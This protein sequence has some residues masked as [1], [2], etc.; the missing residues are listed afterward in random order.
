[1][2]ITVAPGE[3]FVRGDFKETEVIAVIVTK[4]PLI[5]IIKVICEDVYGLIG[6][7]VGF[8]FNEDD[9]FGVGQG[10]GDV[11]V[12]VEVDELLRI[13]AGDDEDAPVEPDKPERNEVGPLRY[14]ANV[15]DFVFSPER[16]PFSSHNKHYYCAS[17]TTNRGQGAKLCSV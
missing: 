4:I 14:R 15:L 17:F 7:D 13:G 9:K 10:Q 6:S 11:L 12:V 3:N 8:T 2:I 1:V 5:F 16:L